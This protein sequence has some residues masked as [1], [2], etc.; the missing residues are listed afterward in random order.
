MLMYHMNKELKGKIII[1]NLKFLVQQKLLR[2][3]DIKR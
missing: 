1:L 2:G 3:A